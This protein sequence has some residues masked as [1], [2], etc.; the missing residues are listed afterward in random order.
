MQPSAAAAEEAKQDAEFFNDL[1]PAPIASATPPELNAIKE[2]II[3][4]DRSTRT[5]KELQKLSYKYPKS[6]EVAYVMGQFYCSKLWMNDGLESFRKALRL[7]PALRTNPYLIK[8][9]AAGL[10]SDGEHQKVHRFLV[11]EIGKP[12]APFLEDMLFGAYRQQVKDRA[13]AILNEIR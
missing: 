4:G 8:A 6:V 7:E 12:A 3:R 2:R 10:G 11:Q 13:T 9:A 1:P 5:L